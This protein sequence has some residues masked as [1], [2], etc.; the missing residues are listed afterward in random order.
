[1]GANTKHKKTKIKSVLVT[2]GTGFIGSHV[3][4]SLRD[5]N[6][7]VYIL[8]RTKENFWRSDV[9]FIWG[10]IRDR[11][12]VLELLSKVDGVIHLAGRLGTAETINNPIP[13]VEVN[14]LG[15]LGC[16]FSNRIT[17]IHPIISNCNIHGRNIV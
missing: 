6:I 10:D 13:S 15:S 3:V 7:D 11:S 14:I 5:K 17:I 1:M 12:L 8:A 4:D 9:H 16:S 2:G